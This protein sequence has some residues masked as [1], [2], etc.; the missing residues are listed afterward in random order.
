MAKCTQE[1]KAACITLLESLLSFRSICLISKAVFVK[2]DHV[3]T[4]LTPTSPISPTK[5]PIKKVVVGVSRV[6]SIL[7]LNG[8]RGQRSPLLEAICWTIWW[9][10]K[11]G[12][13]TT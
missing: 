6:Y 9:S 5:S 8:M 7:V 11:R 4:L 12:F 2:G 10:L 13:W 1:Q 3:Y